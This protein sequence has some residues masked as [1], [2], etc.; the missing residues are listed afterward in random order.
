MTE[1]LRTAKVKDRDRRV[2]GRENFVLCHEKICE[3]AFEKREAGHDS[4]GEATE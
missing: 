3:S 4:A 2:Y 1:I